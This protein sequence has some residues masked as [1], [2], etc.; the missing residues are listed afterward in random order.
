MLFQFS[1][2]EDIVLVVRK[3]RSP[4]SNPTPSTHKIRYVS[5]KVVHIFP[6]CEFV[7]STGEKN[8]E[9]VRWESFLCQQKVA[10]HKLEANTHKRKRVQKWTNIDVFPT[11]WEL[12]EYIVYIVLV[13][14]YTS[15]FCLY[16]VIITA[17]LDEVQNY[18][19]KQLLRGKEFSTKSS[20]AGSWL[21]SPRP[22]RGPPCNGVNKKM[23][24]FCCPV[25][26]VTKNLDDFQK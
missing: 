7:P 14:K 13:L 4:T 12:P 25:M 5:S 9:K 21:S 17:K 8:K 2:A 22:P 15:V 10:F 20:V 16:P 26:M 19:R 11:R 24:S 23:L 6:P 1:V 3:F 18:L